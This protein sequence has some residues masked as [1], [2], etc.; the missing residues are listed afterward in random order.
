MICQ[1]FFFILNFIILFI[2]LN[3][4]ILFIR[5]FLFLRSMIQTCSYS[6]TYRLQHTHTHTHSLSDVVKHCSV[7]LNTYIDIHLPSIVWLWIIV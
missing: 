6:G 7:L 2:I 5:T 1:Y 4:I 3:N